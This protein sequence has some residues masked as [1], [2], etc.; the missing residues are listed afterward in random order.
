MKNLIKRIKKK[1]E[2]Q[3]SYEKKNQE[4]LKLLIDHS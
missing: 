4:E 2:D 1:S 3:R